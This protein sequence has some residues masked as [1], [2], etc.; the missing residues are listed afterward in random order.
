MRNH[1]FST[2]NVAIPQQCCIDYQN[3]HVSFVCAGWYAELVKRKIRKKDHK[4]E[5][6]RVFLWL[7][8]NL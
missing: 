2:L 5:F 6:P 4:H 7:S 8:V 1:S 3:I